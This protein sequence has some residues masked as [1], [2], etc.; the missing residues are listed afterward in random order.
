MTLNGTY[1][2]QR[3]SFI[4]GLL[5]ENMCLGDEN[6]EDICSPLVDVIYRSAP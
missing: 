3:D 4:L 6:E 1:K 2:N 5:Q